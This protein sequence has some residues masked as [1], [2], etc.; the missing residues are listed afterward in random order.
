LEMVESFLTANSSGSLCDKCDPS[1]ARYVCTILLSSL[2]YSKQTSILIQH[3]Q[4]TQSRESYSYYPSFIAEQKYLFLA[5]ETR[6]SMFQKIPCLVIS[7][8][9][10]RPHISK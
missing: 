2:P 3:F 6:Y 1:Q 4:W 9:T 8:K 7:S 5:F 10:I